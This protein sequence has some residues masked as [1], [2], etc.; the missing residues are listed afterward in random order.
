MGFQSTSVLGAEASTWQSALLAAL[1]SC[2]LLLC[3]PA[4]DWIVT[5]SVKRLFG[6]DQG[7]TGGVISLPS[8]TKYFPSIWPEDPSIA[9]NQALQS[10]RSTNQGIAVAA[11]NLGCFCGAILTIFIGNP[12]GRRKTIFC[13]CVTMSIGAI[14]QCTSFDLPQFIIG[15]IITGVGN[16]MNTSTVP[17]WQSES[18]K[19]S[20]RGKMVMIEGMLITAGIT[21]SYWVN[22]GKLGNRRDQVQGPVLTLV[23]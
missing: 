12:L 23:R 21:L 9:D 16:G 4:W 19:S 13:G 22:F 3:S 1:T 10:Q 8:F 20:D 18:S 7:V 17:T 15:R 11:Y 6:Y 14:L 5:D 2:T